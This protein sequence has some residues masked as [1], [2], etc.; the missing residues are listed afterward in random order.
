M[1]RM[2]PVHWQQPS[3]PCASQGRRARQENGVNVCVVNSKIHRVPHLGR[4]SVPQ[5]QCVSETALKLV[6]Q[7]MKCLCHALSAFVR[8]KED[9]QKRVFKL[10]LSL[11]FS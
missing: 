8:E 10:T 7:H 5:A 4:L 11:S 3:P 2:G 1:W 6:P 9:I